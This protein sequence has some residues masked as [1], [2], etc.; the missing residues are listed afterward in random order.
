MKNQELK[1]HKSY[2]YT[3]NICQLHHATDLSEIEGYDSPNMTGIV[4]KPD[5]LIKNIIVK[6]NFHG[7]AFKSL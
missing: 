7:N 2:S 1:I 4:T 3:K 6:A 5:R